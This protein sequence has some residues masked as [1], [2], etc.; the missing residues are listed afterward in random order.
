MQIK[1]MLKSICLCIK[2]KTNKQTKMQHCL[3][4]IQNKSCSLILKYSVAAL[5]LCL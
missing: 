5:M 4:V 3:N 2:Y 1:H